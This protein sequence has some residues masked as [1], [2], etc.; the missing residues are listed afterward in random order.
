M[1]WPPN[2]SLNVHGLCLNIF[3]SLYYINIDI[4]YPYNKRESKLSF[5][6]PFVGHDIP[7]MRPKIRPQV[8]TNTH[9]HMCACDSNSDVGIHYTATDSRGGTQKS[10]M[11]R[12]VLDFF[13]KTPWIDH[14]RVQSF[15]DFLESRDLKS[16]N[17]DS[18]CGLWWKA[19]NQWIWIRYRMVKWYL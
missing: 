3:G 5:R 10:F 1:P 7:W 16:S 18:E 2:G 14:M 8:K 6:L 13:K 12:E 15:Q 17:Y 11:E 9:V 19:K 4:R